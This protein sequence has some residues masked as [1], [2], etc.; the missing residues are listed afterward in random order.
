MASE[1][2]DIR[3]PVAP[4]APSLQADREAVAEAP[5]LYCLGIDTRN[6][7]MMLSVFDPDAP[8]TGMLRAERAED[9]VPKLQKGAAA[10]AATM[11]SV[12]NQYVVL[13]GDN[14]KC[15]SYCR[16]Y[17]FNEK[18]VPPRTAVVIYKDEL[19]RTPRGW[20]ITAR[21]SEH[22]WQEDW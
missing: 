7:A 1:I 9:Y 8:V 21:A 17:H 5:R 6:L 16:A 14:A 18:G 2:S 20:I 11:H 19:K 3:G 15:W 13:D 10:Y 12:S 22:Q 4:L